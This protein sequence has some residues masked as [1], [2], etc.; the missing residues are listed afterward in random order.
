MWNPVRGQL[1]R[2]ITPLL[3][4]LALIAP[5]L[6]ASAQSDE[7]GP[8]GIVA[9][10][11]TVTISDVLDSG[12][13]W[14]DGS[15][16]HIRGISTLAT[17]EGDLSGSAELTSDL[18][19]PGPCNAALEC[20][21]GQDIFTEV[22]ITNDEAIWAGSL[23]LEIL[24]DGRSTAHGIL[25][26]RFG[27]HDQVIVLD[28][29][30]ATDGATLELGG[31]L[32]TLD[33]PI[34]G[35]HLTG[36]ACV[37]GSTTADGGFIGSSGL[38]VDS[39]PMRVT[40]QTLGGTDPT[41][42]YGEVRQ[43]GQKGNLRGIFIAPLNAHH[44]HG[45]FVLV[46]ESGPYHGLLGYGRATATITEESRC[47]SGLQITSTWT[48]QVRY[49]TDPAAFLAPRVYFVAPSD[50][51]KVSTPISLQFGAENVIIEAAGEVHDGAGHFTIIVDSPCIGPG[52]PIP[53]DDLHYQLA[54]GT[55]TINLTIYSGIHRL[56][57]QLTDGNGI[58]QPA[59]DVITIVV[60]PS[61][62]PS[63]GF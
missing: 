45:D 32:V 19:Q 14:F 41:G 26:G 35:I 33:G 8:E 59:S 38:V 61:D 62:G 36:S 51:A 16:V 54:D 23:A 29:L 47:D 39:G 3:L 11:I 4:V 21:G 18:D 42:I 17:V 25:M 60:A 37:T 50:G 6:Q 15:G 1:A 55:S 56:C 13:S 27:T 24:S 34:A 30:T 52:E 2:K 31:R 40:R 44:A 63:D 5:V 43:I 22:K 9:I 58:A 49:V 10:S 57:L 7:G 28:S 48:G 20:Q 12:S 53:D 46:G